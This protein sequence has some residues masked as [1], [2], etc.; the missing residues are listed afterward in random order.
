MQLQKEQQKQQ[1]EQ[2]KLQAKR[3]LTHEFEED[4]LIE[5]FSSPEKRLKTSQPT[6]QNNNNPYYKIPKKDKENCSEST[7]DNHNAK[8]NPN[9]KKDITT[10][11]Q[12]TKSRKRTQAH[13]HTNPTK[14][15]TTERNTNRNKPI[16]K[17]TSTNKETKTATSPNEPNKI[18]TSPKQHP[19]EPKKPTGRRDKIKDLFNKGY[20]PPSINR[21]VQEEQTRLLI[22]EYRTITRKQMTEYSNRNY[23]SSLL[24][25]N[26]VPEG[27]RFSVD[28]SLNLPP[29]LIKEWSDTHKEASRSF[30]RIGIKCHDE[31]IVK[32]QNDKQK[33]Q[34]SLTFEVTD[35]IDEELI[36]EFKNR[37]GKKT[38]E[39]K[40]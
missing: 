18:S 39:R 30:M 16:E 27:F 20:N 7:P 5:Q 22:T 29:H 4:D 35:S 19:T 37:K 2:K 31:E 24:E 25:I 6:D 11:L 40:Q 15:N 13:N 23:L 28:T 26:K 33:L 36:E 21:Q 12:P 1:Q 10:T 38:L 9:N 14:T 8:S 32:L 3:S 34:E 17:T